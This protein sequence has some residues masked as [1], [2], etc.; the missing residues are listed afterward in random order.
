MTVAP[1]NRRGKLGNT[2]VQAGFSCLIVTYQ[3]C[4]GVLVA[5]SAKPP[6]GQSGMIPD[7][8]ITD[9]YVFADVSPTSQ[10]LC[11]E[12]VTVLTVFCEKLESVDR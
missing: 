1:L 11:D 12:V 4:R 2:E 7:V 5:I 9:F 8:L 3:Y 10:A 6:A